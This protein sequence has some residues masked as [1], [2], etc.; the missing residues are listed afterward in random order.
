ML[1][2]CNLAV[3]PFEY[4][5]KTTYF[6]SMITSVWIYSNTLLCPN[7]NNS[8][9]GVYSPLLIMGTG[10]APKDRTMLVFSFLIFMMSVNWIVTNILARRTGAVLSSVLVTVF[11]CVIVFWTVHCL[12]TVRLLIVDAVNQNNLAL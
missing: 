9:S 5:Q 4:W 10:D 2:C 7:A 6:F 11:Y 12:L 8:Y 1:V 3:Y